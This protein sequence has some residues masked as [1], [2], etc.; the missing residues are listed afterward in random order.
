M[1]VPKS[2]TKTSGATSGPLTPKHPR[3]QSSTRH[4]R[5]RRFNNL[6]NCEICKTSIPGSNPGGA[7]NPKWS[8]L[9]TWVTVYSDGER[10]G[11]GRRRHA[12]SRSP[13]LRN[14]F[15]LTPP[16]PTSCGNRP[17]EEPL[18]HASRLRRLSDSM[19]VPLWSSTQRD[20]VDAGRTGRAAAPERGVRP[21]GFTAIIRGSLS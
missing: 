15:A 12:V 11:S 4:Q 20:R 3:K 19:R 2:L 10:Q 18:T 17:P 14:R 7:S 9:D 13:I 16:P 5:A 8:V 1:R 6:D 21:P